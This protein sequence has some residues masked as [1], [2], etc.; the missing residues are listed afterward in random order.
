MSSD[1]NPILW[2]LQELA[3]GDRVVQLTLE[4]S[5]PQGWIASIGVDGD[6][7]LEAQA[8]TPQQAMQ[9]L[10]DRAEEHRWNQ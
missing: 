2:A 9:A 8:L 4:P 5:N 7:M 10:E 6:P 3:V 1:P